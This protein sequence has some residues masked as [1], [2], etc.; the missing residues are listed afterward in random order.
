MEKQI[1]QAVMGFQLQDVA[2][3]FSLHKDY[4]ALRLHQYGLYL[5]MFVMTITEIFYIV[6]NLIFATR[7]VMFIQYNDR[8]PHRIILWATFIKNAVGH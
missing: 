5:Q 4:E 6:K 8:E 2:F 1:L 3:F 7:M